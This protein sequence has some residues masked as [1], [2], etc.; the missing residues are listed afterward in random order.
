MIKATEFHYEFL[1]QINRVN[2]DFN[3]SISVAARDSYF[4]HAKEVVLENYFAIAESN[5]TVRNHLRQLEVKKRELDCIA[6]DDTCCVVS[7]PLDFYRL[8]R[9]SADLCTDKCSE[10]RTVRIHTIQ[11][12]DIS[13]SLKDPYWEPSFEWEET[14]GEEGEEGYYV[15]IKPGYDVKKV[16]IDYLRKPGNIAAPS[17]LDCES[18]CYTNS[19]GEEVCN[20]SDFDVDSTWLWRKIV[21][22]S[23]VFALRD[24]GQV[25]DV[26]SKMEEIIFVD[27]AYLK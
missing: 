18:K 2:S 22:V 27:K 4:N 13:E 15:Y 24:L 16:Y 10:V 11:T 14:F 19:K 21:D 8:L 26:R 20:D 25:D 9:Q 7:F 1:K 6:K 23:V 17:L 12:D 3:K 5:S